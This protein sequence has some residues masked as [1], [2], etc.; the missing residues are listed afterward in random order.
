MSTQSIPIEPSHQFVTLKQAAELLGFPYWKLLRAA[1]AGCF[2]IYRPFNS[3]I[4]VR[5]PE[6]VIYIEATLQTGGQ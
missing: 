1:R 3:R 2:P 4:V 5:L 6:I